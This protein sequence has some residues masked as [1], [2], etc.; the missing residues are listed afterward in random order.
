MMMTH[1]VTV[2]V[3]ENG[4]VILISNPPHHG[5]HFTSLTQ[6]TWWFIILLSDLVRLWV[7]QS[8][9]KFAVISRSIVSKKLAFR[10]FSPSWGNVSLQVCSQILAD[11]LSLSSATICSLNIEQKMI[12]NSYSSS[13]SRQLCSNG[14]PRPSEDVPDGLCHSLPVNLSNTAWAQK[15]LINKLSGNTFGT[16]PSDSA[17]IGAG[18]NHRAIF[19]TVP[20]I[21]AQR[22]QTIILYLAPLPASQT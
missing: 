9:V 22:V 8:A 5:L 15:R 12:V 10:R 17:I 21:R 18:L 19:C 6:L 14:S 20:K 7:F 1:D 2:I 16:G 3:V 11:F 4:V 13:T